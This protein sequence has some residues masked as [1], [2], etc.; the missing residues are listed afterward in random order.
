MHDNKDAE[1]EEMGEDDENI[2]RGWLKLY[3][4]RTVRESKGPACGKMA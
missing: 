4:V 1:V 2:L 3:A